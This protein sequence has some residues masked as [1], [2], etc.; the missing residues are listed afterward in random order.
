[1]LLLLLLN[2]FGTFLL[3]G[4]A[5]A[6]A[7]TDQKLLLILVDGFRWDYLD[8]FFTPGELRGFPKL[9]E[10]GVR[11]DRQTP[12]FPTLSYVNY[13]SL[14]TGLHA[15]THGMIHNYMYD[16]PHKTF[17]LIGENEDQYKP[18]WWDDGEPLWV[19]AR[20][21]GKRSY[22][23]YWAGCE[24]EIRGYRPEFCQPYLSSP[25]PSFE[26]FTSA[27]NGAVEVLKNGSADVAG[28]F[29]EQVD[30]WGHYYG[31]FPQ[32]LQ[33]KD[34]IRKVD[35][36]IFRVLNLLETTRFNDGDRRPLSDKVNVML[37]SD[38]GMTERLD[39]V[40]AAIIDYDKSIINNATD[41][42][43]GSKLGPILQIY[44]NSD[45][46]NL[47]YDYFKSLHPHLHVY[48][49]NEIS[50]R[51]YYKRHPRVP[52]LLLV[53]DKGYVVE[54][55]PTINSSAHV[56]VGF[57]GYDNELHDMHGIFYAKGP[58]FQKRKRVTELRGIDL[59]QVMC[60]VLEIK[61]SPNNGTWSEV[62]QFLSDEAL[63]GS[64]EIQFSASAVL[65]FCL[66][67][68]TITVRRVM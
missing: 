50:D 12:Q 57:H 52:H 58:Y 15:E 47:L 67:V 39:N 51:Y 55:R 30:H 42:V 28:V 34:A 36:E 59:Y 40:S 54:N 29:F 17:F 4:D 19:T 61:A 64:S 41:I 24:V 9:Q 43:I 16:P 23:W 46:V 60:F 65:F 1:M 48:R 21:Q 37:F 6:T 56:D 26:N 35:E 8:I 38:H 32:N 5:T 31:P 33:L 18:Y 45:R 68:A 66:S 10:M 20:K 49:K 14:M 2:A 11:V 3:F 44:T 13:Y 27:L 22:W 25:N 53:T 7:A 63:Y 62:I